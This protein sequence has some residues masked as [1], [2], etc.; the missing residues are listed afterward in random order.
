MVISFDEEDDL[1]IIYDIIKEEKILTLELE[2]NVNKKKYIKKKRRILKKRITLFVITI[3]EE[4][5]YTL[6]MS[7][8]S[9]QYSA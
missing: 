6:E 2:Y 5:N 9:S 7:L 1:P 4:P 8:D 3:K